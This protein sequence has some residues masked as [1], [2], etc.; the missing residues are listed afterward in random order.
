VV[1]EIAVKYNVTIDDLADSVKDFW[2]SEAIR[3]VDAHISFIRTNL[4]EYVKSRE[5]STVTPAV[6][7]VTCLKL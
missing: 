1:T 2:R 3:K 6:E 5:D 7:S 4:H